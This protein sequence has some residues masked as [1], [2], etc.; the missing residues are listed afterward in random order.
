[1]QACRLRAACPTTVPLPSRARIG[2]GEGHFSRFMESR[3]VRSC[4]RLLPAG[5]IPP[6]LPDSG[7]QSPTPTSTAA[8]V[9]LLPFAEPVFPPPLPPLAPPG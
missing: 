5:F 7:R 9:P 6:C 1:M 4:G 8:A 3:R 2:C